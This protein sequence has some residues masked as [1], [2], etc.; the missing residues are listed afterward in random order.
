METVGKN[1][2]DANAKLFTFGLWNAQS[3][4]NK[5]SDIND[6]IM[7][8]DLD[9]Y[10]ITESWLFKDDHK[11]IGDLKPIGYDFTHV[12]RDS[13]QG[14]GIASIYKEELNIRKLS[15][16]IVTTMEIME[17]LL[18]VNSIKIRFVVI[19]RPPPS[20]IKNY[21]MSLFYSE[22]YELMAHY[23]LLSEEFIVCGDFNFHVNDSCS[24]EAMQFMDILSEF[25][26]IQHIHGPTQKSGNTLDLVITRQTSLITGYKIDL[27]MSDHNI[28]LCNLCLRKSP[29]E[30]K[31]ITFRKLKSI[32]IVSFKMDVRDILSFC[33]NGA[34]LDTLVDFYNNNLQYILDK[35]A[36]EQHR[37]VAMRRPTPWISQ[38]I[39]PEKQKRRK[40]E[41]IWRRTQQEDDYNAFKAQKIRVNC[42]LED[43]KSKYYSGLISEN[44]SNPK[45]LF[46]C[47]NMALHRKQV[48]PLPPHSSDLA[49]ANEFSE[50]F[51]GKIQVIRDNLEKLSPEKTPLLE[52][53]KYRTVF[54]T[55]ELVTEDDVKKLVLKAPK[56]HCTLDPLPTWL[57][58]ECLEELLPILT[59]IVNLSLQHGYMPDTLKHAIIN[60][61]L[62]K[63]GL[64]LLKANFRPVS[65]L[66]FLAKLI[67]R[68]ASSQIIDHM[69]TNDLTE[70]FQSAYCM[71]HSTETALVRVQ[72]DILWELDNQNIVLLILLDLSAAFDTIDHAILLNRLS[73]RFGIKGTAL[74]WFTSYLSN[75]TQ[76]VKIER[77]YSSPQPLKF[78]IPQGSV[79][80]P[81]L[82]TMY[83][84]PLGD[85]IAR[86]GVKY[87]LYAD[88]TQ[89]YL[90][91]SP[92]DEIEQT[93]KLQRM[94]KCI[95]DIRS[96]MT[97]NRLQL[98]DNK[99]EFIIIGTSQQL[100]KVTFNSIQ[101]GDS[102][103]IAVDEARNLG[104]I[105]D[106]EMGLKT[107]IR[108]IRKK[109]FFHV[110]N[111]SSIRRYLDK[112]S[113]KTAVHAFVTST[114]DCGNALLYGLPSSQ[115][116]RL[117]L[118]QNA[119]ARVVERVKKFD[120]ITHIRKALHWLPVQ[121]RINF[122]IL[123]LTWKALHGLAPRYLSELLKYKSNVR[124]LRSSGK[125]LLEVPRTKLVTCGDRTFR[126]AA[127]TLWNSLPA[128][129]HEK[130]TLEAFKS[131]LKTHLFS[132]SYD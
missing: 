61:L 120:R 12:P 89:L 63:L 76:S 10:L 112:N 79:M 4:R 1:N 56:K 107:H 60:P 114:L 33:H 123:V 85:I 40:L 11:V 110:K 104:V 119:A 100:K 44:A 109:G 129:L 113:T 9:V 23:V 95:Q 66:A 67:E 72:N 28:I 55:F 43:S 39:R 62:K 41:R 24:D 45:N 15:A 51:S 13:R 116:H 57:M 74:Q 35:H 64:E 99:T 80:G 52:I 81:I 17:L 6:Y 69:T 53:S 58:R 106:K 19:Y 32:N 78:G 75:R 131:G 126:K 73:V 14:G 48:S 8:H 105:F 22:F 121:A 54:T 47:L 118:V 18:T 98:N 38:D 86:H 117:Q 2:F 16:P 25:D 128:H 88:D 46:K 42:M 115:L 93:E 34:N 20:K 97:D 132:L 127:P 96:W 29:C 26:L 71:Y 50:F 68:A 82:F 27:Q 101:V 70:I 122:K 37:Q 125:M 90:S 102:K 94:E 49:L 7:E 108:H 103:I 36:P 31:T 21:S 111:I 92:I 130:V 30:T 5:T 124:R 65:N 77:K 83:T 59:R 84:S 91:F 87:H 3:A